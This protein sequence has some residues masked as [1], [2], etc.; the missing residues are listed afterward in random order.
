MLQEPEASKASQSL[1]ERER[2][3]RK[4]KAYF[5]SWNGI[6]SQLGSSIIKKEHERRVKEGIKKGPKNRVKCKP[7]KKSLESSKMKKWKKPHKTALFGD[8]N[9]SFYEEK[10]LLS[11]S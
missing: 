9:T 3:I 1:K 6:R 4:E 10:S 2:V 8:E 11:K 7:P 5:H